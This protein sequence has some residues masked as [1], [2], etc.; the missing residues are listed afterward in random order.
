M[1]GGRWHQCNDSRR[2][3]FGEPAGDKDSYCKK[4]QAGNSRIYTRGLEGMGV[5]KHILKI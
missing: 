3:A 2:E 4:W 1:P 5:K